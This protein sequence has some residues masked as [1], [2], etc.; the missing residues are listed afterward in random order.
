MKLVASPHLTIVYTVF[1]LLPWGVYL[2]DNKNRASC[3][4]KTES[5]DPAL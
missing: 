2:Q 3:V 5:K 1:Q 4:N